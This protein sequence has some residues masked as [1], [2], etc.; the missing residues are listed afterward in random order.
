[1]ITSE[2]VL[3]YA[4]KMVVVVFKLKILE[5]FE[6]LAKKSKNWRFFDH[7][8]LLVQVTPTPPPPFESIFHGGQFDI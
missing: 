1:M 3:L 2:H 8:S 5:R 7:F 6:V 4:P